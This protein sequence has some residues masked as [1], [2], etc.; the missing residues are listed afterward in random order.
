VLLDGGALFIAVASSNCGRCG[1]PAF[2][3]DRHDG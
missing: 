1:S 3:H 2:R